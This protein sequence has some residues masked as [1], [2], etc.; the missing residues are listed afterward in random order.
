MS[1]DIYF[2]RFKAGEADSAG[3]EEALRVLG[4]FLSRHAPEGS[5]IVHPAGTA[6]VYGLRADEGGMMVTHVNGEGL[7]NLLA[8]TAIAAQWT[9]MPVGCRTCVFSSEMQAE[10][11]DGLKENVAI[12]E[13]GEDLLRVI[14]EG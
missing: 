6:E 2:Q 7:W 12:I 3:S 4:P 1:F 14:T 5:V 10:L 11:P 9:V 8:A 13:T